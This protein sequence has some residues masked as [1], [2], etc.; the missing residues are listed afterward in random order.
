MEGILPRLISIENLEEIRITALEKTVNVQIRRKEDY[1]R[2]IPANHGIREQG[3]ILLYNNRHKE[4][5]G[6]LHTR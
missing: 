6:K 2:K 3:L 5:P 1:D 4:F